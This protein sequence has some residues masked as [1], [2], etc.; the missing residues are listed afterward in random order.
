MRFYPFQVDDFLFWMLVFEGIRALC[1]V[2]WAGL[3]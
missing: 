1:W 3:Q 2:L